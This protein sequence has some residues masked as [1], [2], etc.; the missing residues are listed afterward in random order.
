V[1]KDNQNIDKLI[2]DKF[3]TYA[4]EP[5]KH[6]WHSV[7]KGINRKPSVIASNKY[8]I[9][10]SILVLLTISFVLFYPFSSNQDD[11]SIIVVNADNSSNI[12]KAEPASKSGT[13]IIVLEE[14]TITKKSITKTS[15]SNKPKKV[16]KADDKPSFKEPDEQIF[17]VFEYK[18]QFGTG[19]IGS[20][21]MKHDDF[22]IN[23]PE[24]V[25]EPMERPENIAE[26]EKSEANPNDIIPNEERTRDSHWQIGI[27]IWPELT[28]SNIDS[29]EILNTYN[30]NIEP[31]YYIN[32]HW[33]IRT[34][35]GLSYVQDRGF[36]QIKYNTNELMGSYEDVYNITFDSIDGIVT[37]TY[38]TKT[39][40]V[41]DSV[42][43]FTVSNITNKYLYLQIPLS[44]GYSSKINNSSFN[45]YVYGGSS[46]F[47]RT[48]TW[49]DTP[50]LNQTDVDIIDLNNDLPE[51]VSTYFQ[52]WIGA[53][54]G[55]DLN[56]NFNL[57]LEPTYNNYLTNVYDN[58]NY[59]GPTSG[60]SLRLGLVY[61][62][63]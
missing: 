19:V 57:T 61:K 60:F 53:G 36:A 50:S 39:V 35:L 8:L 63:K 48:N 15:K 55:Y 14:N 7:E 38:Y 13:E 6:I 26:E 31:T 23:V 42:K 22:T 54:I 3:E 33:F 44:I 51:R 1:E 43:H 52:L 41:Y 46:M 21:D 5:P 32:D 16:L 62:L 11:T 18:S 24:K 56:D 45:W 2:R 47:I 17:E 30:L 9:A 40:E 27:N 4:P 10:A 37:P 34:G 28:V 25:I 59:K 58:A 20:L 49:L 12:I 29:V